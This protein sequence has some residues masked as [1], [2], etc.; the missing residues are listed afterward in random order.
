MPD[1]PSRE[2]EL[3][4]LL[5]AALDLSAE[6]WRPFLEEA[7]SDLEI[8]RE[9]EAALRGEAELGS[10]MAAPAV[11]AAD[12]G[13]PGPRP[14]SRD[15][16][17]FD[18]VAEAVDVDPAERRRFL[19]QRSDD[20][21][22]IDRVLAL[23]ESAAAPP[24]EVATEAPTL[25][26][27]RPGTTVEVPR[28]G[29]RPGISPPYWGRF[30][31]RRLLGA[32]GMGLV[33]EAFDPELQ[34][35]VALKLVKAPTPDLEAR[36][37]REARAQARIDHENVCQVYEVGKVE[38]RPYI[39]MQY[40][41]GRTLAKAAPDLTLEK[42]VQVMAA[43]CEGLHAAH[44]GGLVHR[45]VKPGN[46]MVGET[47]DGGLS[48]H[49]MDF[50]IARE[51]A[52]SD[53]TQTGATLGTPHYMA[54]EQVDDSVGDLDRRTDVYGLGATLYKLLTGE[55]PF[56][57]NPAAMVM[58]RVLEQDPPSPRRLVPSLPRDLET[59]V[60]KCL[61]KEPARRYPSAR[62]LYEDLRRYLDGEPI[63]A[64]RASWLYRLRHR[65]RKHRAALAVAA[66]A[67]V[68]IAAALGSAVAERLRA[69]AIAD[70]AQRFGREAESLTWIQRA[71]HQ[72][73][74]HDVRAER[75]LLR[76]RM[77][78]IEEMMA[79]LGPAGQGPALYALGRGHLALSETEAARARLST[80]WDL[81][82][83][84]P[85]VAEAL[86]QTLAARYETALAQARRVS[87]RAAREAR[88]RQIEER[89]RRPA[90]EFLRR[91]RDA[92]LE[93]P[94]LTEAR[95]ALLEERWDEAEALARSAVERLPWRYGGHLIV[96]HSAAERAREAEER[97]A[98]DEAE[99]R[100]QEAEAA[101]G[102]A[103]RIGTSDPETWLALCRL[104]QSRAL[105]VQDRRGRDAG[106]QYEQALAACGKSLVADPDHPGALGELAMLLAQRADA[107]QLRGEDPRPDLERAEEAS[108]RAVAAAPSAIGGWRA[109]GLTKL[110]EGVDLADRGQDALPALDEAIASLERVVE[111]DAEFAHAHHLLSWALLERAREAG[112]R[113]QDPEPW[114]E[115]ASSESERAIELA[116]R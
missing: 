96:G 36:F 50:G 75:E 110:V 42:K 69:R 2:A 87:D 83:R 16:R 78:D 88:L 73:P 40:L 8:A 80:A 115:R 24:E 27:P 4:R 56:A 101:Y 89:H 30:L 90:L 64:R 17:F 45:D 111:L 74:L 14:Q 114:L 31:V 58:H 7:A 104:E 71:S 55:T 99:A 81:G 43:A 32:G 91:G 53:L 109:L 44:R 61:E 54:P 39:A 67:A 52:G 11:A 28:P 116:P 21:S 76:Q 60:L 3:N 77:R 102:R 65:A 63:E 6:R 49:V 13:G 72:L 100:Y 68:L 20:A 66:V 41:E 94:E 23:L 103:V 105:L 82:Y 106:P 98:Y 12:L 26:L 70:A 57:G 33:L 113:Q 18:L 112:R 85:A 95:I 92:D 15:L 37:Q 5:A 79:E 22:L 59:I 62:A 19:E 10:F 35:R 108:R 34:R 25:A 48:V 9:A 38:G 84:E 97:G 107:L 46:V 1:V 86:G 47:P 51:I 93:A 29:N